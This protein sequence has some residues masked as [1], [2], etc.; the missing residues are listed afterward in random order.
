MDNKDYITC[1]NCGRKF[2]LATDL[3]RH[4]YEGNHCITY[5]IDYCPHCFHKF[6]V[7]TKAKRR[8]GVFDK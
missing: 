2:M 4:K 7:L 6:E 5:Y 8:R 3:R 1:G